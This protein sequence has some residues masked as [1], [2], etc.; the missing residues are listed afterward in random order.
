MSYYLVDYENVKREGLNAINKLTNKDKVSIF[1]SENA[2]TLSFGLHRRLN[3]SA[4][5][6][7]YQK[8]EVGTKNALDFQLVTFLGFIIANKEDTSYCIVTK[9]NGFNSVCN[10]WSKKSINV[11]IVA[12]LSGRDLNQERDELYAE[13][14]KC[15]GDVEMSN[16]V[17]DII[18]QYKTKQGINN[19]LIKNFPSKDHK[20]ASDIYKQIKPLLKDKKG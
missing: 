8:V 2:D 13:V 18:L 5:Q 6:I 10:Y 9:D 12:D 1:Y 16:K 7:T 14:N 3:E 17:T 15:I 11:T 19:A 4:A 20:Q